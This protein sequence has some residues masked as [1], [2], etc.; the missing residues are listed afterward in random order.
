MNL[1]DLDVS[2]L[3]FLFDGEGACSLA[4]DYDAFSAQRCP[5]FN[6]NYVDSELD[7]VIECL[8]KGEKHF[9]E[10]RQELQMEKNRRKLDEHVQE[11]SNCKIDN[12]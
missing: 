10:I 5:L 2:C 8:K 4:G 6:V 1:R 12:C 3:D 9:R 7:F 11:L